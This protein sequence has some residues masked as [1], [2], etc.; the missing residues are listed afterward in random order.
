MTKGL[1][2]SLSRGPA[3]T[4]GVIK[5]TFVLDA[6]AITVDGAA[7]V[8]V[9]TV[10]LGD[11]PEGNVLFLGAVGYMEVSGPGASANLVDT[12]SGD[13]GVGTTPAD[14]ATITAG[15]IDIVGSTALGPAVAEVSP[16]TR[17][18]S[19]NADT[20]EVHDNTDGSLELNLNVLVDDADIDADGIACTVTGIL[21]I[22][23]VMLLND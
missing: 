23:Y 13:F 18:I 12:W 15:D 7:G 21:Q 4:R 22:S 11:L 14:D 8:G 6:L 1:E 16:R 5:D 19:V 10:A 9:G 17:G 2:R 3:L 20:G